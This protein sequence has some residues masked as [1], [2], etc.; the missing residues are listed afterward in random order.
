MKALCERK[1]PA[2]LILHTQLR[3]IHVT[4]TKKERQ[5]SLFQSSCKQLN[6]DW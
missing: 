2:G 5:G 3:K 6:R 1:H 4:L